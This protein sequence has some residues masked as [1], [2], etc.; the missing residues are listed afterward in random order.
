MCSGAPERCYPCGI[1][2]GAG[3]VRPVLLCFEPELCGQT[4][5]VRSRRTSETGDSEDLDGAERRFR[6]GRKGSLG[7]SMGA[8][9]ISLRKVSE[10]G[11][12]A[13]GSC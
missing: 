9:T 7:K 10:K 11:K 13:A 4:G 2:P 8:G 6:R 12:R 5:A 1:G 3:Y